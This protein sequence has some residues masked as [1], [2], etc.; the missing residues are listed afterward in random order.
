MTLCGDCWLET[1]SPGCGCTLVPLSVWGAKSFNPVP[2]RKTLLKI[3]EED[4]LNP[5]KKGGKFYIVARKQEYKDLPKNLYFDGYRF[6]YRNPQT[7]ERTWL[8]VGTTEHEAKAAAIAANAEL[9][10]PTDLLAKILGTPDFSKAADEWILRVSESDKAANTKKQYGAVHKVLCKTFAGPINAIT[11]RGIAD[12]LDTQKPSMRNFYRLALVNIY[13]IAVAKG[14][15]DENLPERTEKP[16][17]PKRERPR[18]TLSQFHEIRDKAPEWLVIAMDLALYSLQR[19]GD[20][21]RLTYDDVQD[22]YIHL[23]QQ[24]T[25]AAIRIEVGPKLAE[26]ISRSKRSNVHS[27]FI[28]HKRNKANP[29][30]TSVSAFQLQSEWR[31]LQTEKPYPTFHEIRSLGITMYRDKGI[32]PQGLAGHS[33]EG[34]TDSYDQEVR[35]QEVGTL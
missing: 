27:K 2:D 34:M 28:V 7:G 26:V 16:R 6:R 19:Q 13:G 29:M 5:Q 23:I 4:G 21:L 18:L 12:F 22:G 24:K 30:K 1:G 14:W 31:K 3:A 20:I 11:L 17:K 15:V 33:T 25:G 10:P 35:Y 8:P 32:D 9:D